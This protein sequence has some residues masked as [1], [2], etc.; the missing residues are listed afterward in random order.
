MTFLPL[1]ETS[2]SLL[3]ATR[4]YIYI[5]FPSINKELFQPE[6][7]HIHIHTLTLELAPRNTKKLEEEKVFPPSAMVFPSLP[8]F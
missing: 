5:Y 3:C 2:L 7:Y 6:Y 8:S 4:L 1:A